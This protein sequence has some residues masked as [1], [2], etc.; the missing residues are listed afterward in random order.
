MTSA[1][2]AGTS[3]T[4]CSN[5]LVENVD[6]SIIVPAYQAAEHL[7]EQLE[8]L[9]LQETLVRWELIVADNG[10]TDGTSALCREHAARGL[11]LRWIDA[12]ARRGPA[13]ARNEGARHARG[14]LLLFCDADDVACPRWID[15][16]TRALGRAE[17]VAGR[18][19]PWRVRAAGARAGDDPQDSDVP[20]FYGRPYVVTANLGCTMDLFTKLRGFDEELHTGEDIDFGFRAAALGIEPMF[21]PEAVMRYRHRTKPLHLLHQATAY[22]SIVPVVLDRHD[23]PLPT[24]ADDLRWYFRLL[25]Q[26]LRSV[27]AP[28]SVLWSSAYH[29]ART[30]AL[31]TRPGYWRLAT[32]WS[33]G[34]PSFLDVQRRRLG[35]VSR[36]RR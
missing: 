20:A 32:R 1:T 35:R 29:L 25:K 11:P 10:S 7:D 26:S 5:P 22:G 4:S 14:R 19:A 31:V 17:L 16:M 9:R 8:A 30:R 28:Q 24:I 34:G 27:R 21:A 6:V 33:G 18:L 2:G 15:E 36:V 23:I 13:H 12:S 3:T